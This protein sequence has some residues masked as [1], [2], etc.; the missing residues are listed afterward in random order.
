LIPSSG[1]ILNAY[2]KKS[3]MMELKILVETPLTMLD[4]STRIFDS[5]FRKILECA[6]EN[7]PE[8]GINNLVETHLKILPVSTRIFDFFFRKNLEY[9][10]EKIPEE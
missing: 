7:I 2:L 10:F 5:F 4:V 1:K 9:I 6:I 3:L 8:D